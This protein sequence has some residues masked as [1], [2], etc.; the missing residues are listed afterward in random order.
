MVQIFK[1]IENED[2]K[3][4]FSLNIQLN[5]NSIILLVIQ[6]Q[7]AWQVNISQ[8]SVE[9]FA[10]QFNVSN[11]EYYAKLKTYLLETPRN[12][13][14]RFIKGEFCCYSKAQNGI[15]LKYF[16]TR[17]LKIELN[18]NELLELYSLE[19]ERLKRENKSIIR[20]RDQLKEVN[21]NLENKLKELV[22][23]K[24]KDEEELYSNFVLVLNEKKR[25]IQH[26]NQLLQ[27]F[28]AGRSVTNPQIIPKG[29]S[30][31][32]VKKEIKNE[33]SESDSESGNDGYNT[34]EEKSVKEDTNIEKLLPS[35][36]KK[37]NFDLFFDEDNN[38]DSHLPKRTKNNN[39]INEP[40]ES[41]P[42]TSKK[43]E[44]KPEEV[45]MEVEEN[46]PQVGCSTQDLLDC[47]D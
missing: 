23:R 38:I 7:N 27:A 42:S 2:S 29:R 26:L 14:F 28:K 31:K 30:K 19:G 3:Q 13:E 16:Y 12:I 18:F 33:V 22:T 39:V 9:N 21:V 10:D 32:E 37:Q 17:P 35:T 44:D 8:D 15:N 40:L 4:Q 36:S 34:D 20:E 1:T 41:K 5:E 11:E 6:K 43:Q 47:I 25:R 24:L 46:S 45:N